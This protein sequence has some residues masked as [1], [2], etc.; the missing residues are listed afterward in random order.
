MTKIF[1][2]YILKYTMKKYP[3]VLY[4]IPK[5]SEHILSTSQKLGIC[6]YL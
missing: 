6:Y 1:S 5:H 2:I 3:E 4:F